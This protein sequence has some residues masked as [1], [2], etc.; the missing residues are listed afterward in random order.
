[1]NVQ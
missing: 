1:L